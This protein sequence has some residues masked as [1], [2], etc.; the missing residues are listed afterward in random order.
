M[1][2]TTVTYTANKY[3]NDQVRV[4]GIDEYKSA[5]RTLADAFF[6]DD[7][8]FYCLE[9]PDNGGMT[10]EELYP[11]HLEILEYIV[12]AHCYN[13]L[14]LGIGEHNEGIA[15]WMPPGKNMDDW[16]T[17]FRSGMWRLYWKLTKE[18]KKRYFEEFLEVLHQTKVNAMGDQDKDA[19]YLVY[20]GVTPDA[21][22][23]GYAR[24]L[25]EFVTRKCDLEGG[26]PCYL[27]S[28]HINN[29]P[30]YQR[31]GFVKKSQVV[32]GP[33]CGKPVPLDIMI[34]PKMKLVGEKLVPV[35]I[36]SSI[37]ASTGGRR[38]VD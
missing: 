29:V 18:G 31:F 7:V 20:L 2:T 11:L 24:K 8:A 13:G 23:R 12:A 19:W 21:R 15:L 10:R 22:G 5:A 9:T 26:A 4:L 35:P 33:N 3:S 16:F 27:E 37:T 36:T 38:L 17:I 32:L 1:S 14:V 34:R 25:I 6:K 28:S 30:M